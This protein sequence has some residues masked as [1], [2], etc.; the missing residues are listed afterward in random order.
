MISECQSAVDQGVVENADMA[1]AGMIFGTGF[2]G[3]RGGPLFW[4]SQQN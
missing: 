2:P 4:A 1:D 3:F